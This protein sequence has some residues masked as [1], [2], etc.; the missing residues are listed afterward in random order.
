VLLNEVASRVTAKSEN[1][2]C[3]FH[4]RFTY[5]ISLMQKN[6]NGHD[7]L[8]EVFRL[9]SDVKAFVSVPNDFKSRTFVR[10]FVNS[11]KF[12]QYI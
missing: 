10:I 4:D 1:S 7:L 9:Q 12:I 6:T 11:F 3:V 5:T 2:K 8:L